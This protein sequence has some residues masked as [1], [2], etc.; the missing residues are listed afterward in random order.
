MDSSQASCSWMPSSHTS[1]SCIPSSQASCSSGSTDSDEDSGDEWV[2]FD[3]ELAH[4][5]NVVYL[6]VFYSIER[7]MCPN[8]FKKFTKF[9]ENVFKFCNSVNLGEASV[10]DAVLDFFRN[11]PAR[12]RR[13][14]WVKFGNWLKS[15]EGAKFG[16]RCEGWS[17]YARNRIKVCK[18]C[19][20]ASMRLINFD[21]VIVVDD[22]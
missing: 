16:E 9:H 1:C 19:R 2:Q 20:N 18:G 5:Y 14:D 11:Y 21:K 22:K 12:V 15:G 8:H 13:L 10:K 6:Q 7:S 4:N 3:M 17:D